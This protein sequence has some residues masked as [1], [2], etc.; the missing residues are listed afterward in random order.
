MNNKNK[1]GNQ[2][3][4]NAQQ[5]P[6]A[7]LRRKA[8]LK[9]K[10]DEGRLRDLSAADMKNL[11]HELGTHQI[12]LEMQN[13]ELRRAR[14]ELEASHAKYVDLYDF[15]PEGYFI[16]DK[17]G[18]IK[19]VNLTG[20]NMLGM[21]KR[22]LRARPFQTFIDPDHRAV[23]RNHLSE[24][25]RTQ[26]GSSCEIV[27]HRSDGAKIYAR[28]HSLS[29][30]MGEGD[31]GVCR[32]AIS[33]ITEQKRAEIALRESEERYRALFERAGDAIFIL[34][35]E[36]MHAGR[37]VAANKT[38]AEMH[39][40]AGDELP[41]A[42]MDL[43][44]SDAAGAWSGLIG[45]IL[46]GEWIKSELDHRRKDGSIFP[47]EISA[48][49]LEYSERKYILVFDRDVTERKRAESEIRKLNEDLKRALLENEAVNKELEAF[50]YSVSHDLRAPLRTIE[51]FTTG[52]L[53]DPATT[54]GGTSKDYFQ[55]VL[56]ASR[57]MSQLIDAMLNMARLT[58]GEL[59]GKTVDLSGLAEVIA[60]ELQ[61]KDPTRR[62][63]FII[64]KGVKAQGDM[65]MLRTVLEN[66]LDNAWKFTDKRP[67]ATIE[68]GV[69]EMR[70]ADS[71]LRNDCHPSPSSSPLGGE[72]GVRGQS[73]TVYFVR[74]DGAGFMMEYADKLFQPFKRLHTADEFSGIGIGLATVKRIILRHGG[75][76]WAESAPEQ[77]STFFF[78]LD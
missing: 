3:K 53:E 63:Q 76:I 19:E 7:E 77:G 1:N 44:P 20:A 24:V 38:A 46:N 17:T 62:V 16:F 26:A 58:K 13:E 59:R 39:G 6:L 47:C 61:K 64:A 15:S 11:V 71:G 36:G 42:I 67:S 54:L 31:P 27:I 23:F 8:E 48:G 51:G 57:R 10:Y 41:F 14:A 75:R 65:D 72:G 28:L 29:F 25:F 55:R 73:E 70:N 37:I 22:L 12:E 52:I 40:Y 5:D 68:F 50:S 49:L 2:K 21:E 66:L 45:R 43:V 18:L 56:S 4:E 30:V 78:T 34:D 60:N 69:M 9:L 32:T 35:A 74:D 33:D